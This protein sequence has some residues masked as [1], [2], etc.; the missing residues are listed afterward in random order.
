MHSNE[1]RK[2]YTGLAITQDSCHRE[3]DLQYTEADVPP[4]RSPPGPL[5]GPLLS[6][7][8]PPLGPDP[9]LPVGV[10][11]GSSKLK[12]VDDDE[13]EVNV[14]DPVVPVVT[15]DMVARSQDV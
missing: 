9:S 7:R 6:P 12:D 4:P 3:E 11:L 1:P 5:L 2:V 15:D 14:G 8:R 10:E 13:K